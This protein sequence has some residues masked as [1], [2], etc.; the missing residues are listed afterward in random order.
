MDMEFTLFLPHDALP[1]AVTCMGS[2]WRYIHIWTRDRDKDEAAVSAFSF[3]RTIHKNLD[4]W[5]GVQ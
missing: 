3:T 1:M 5:I 4:D 2:A